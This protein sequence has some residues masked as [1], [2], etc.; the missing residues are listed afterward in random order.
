MCSLKEEGDCVHEVGGVKRV[1]SPAVP[2]DVMPVYMIVDGR[3][4]APVGGSNPSSCV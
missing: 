2:A 1:E 3:T 4:H